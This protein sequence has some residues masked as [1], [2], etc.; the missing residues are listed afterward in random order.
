L[1]LEYCLSIFNDRYFS[2]I[3]VSYFGNSI[4]IETTFIEKGYIM[5]NIWKSAGTIL[6]VILIITGCSMQGI[7]KNGS[8][9]LNVSKEYREI[10]VQNQ[11]QLP[12]YQLIV[13]NPSKGVF[14][15]GKKIEGQSYFQQVLVKTQTAEKLFSWKATIV[16]PVLTFANVTGSGEENIIIMFVTA[17][18][19]GYFQSQVHVLNKELTREIPVEAPDLAAQRLITSRIDGKD[20]V[21]SAGGKE[22]RVTPRVGPGGIQE[23]YNNIQ[24][25]SVVNYRVENNRLLATVTV[26]TNP[27]SVIGEF[28]LVY[29]FKDGK[30]T[31]QVTGFRRVG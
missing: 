20:I 30:L 7:S 14:V 6:L 8:K 23:A 26:Q 21:F 27:S 13:S 12:G 3:N 9:G 11:P 22:Y 10:S 16:N 29:S 15:Y 1:Y 25:G 28:T 19:T 5:K 18:G 2:R 4:N 31:P 24:F 17:Y